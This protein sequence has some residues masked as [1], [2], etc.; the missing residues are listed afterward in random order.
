MSP[1]PARRRT[2]PVTD[3]A[4]LRAAIENASAGDTITLNADVEVASYVEIT[5]SITIDLAGHKISR[6]GN[7][8]LDPMGEGVTLTVKDSVGG[9]EVASVIPVWVEGGADFV[10]ESGAIRSTATTDG[11]GI[12]ADNAGTVTVKGGTVS[13]GNY[14]IN[15]SGATA[16]TIN[17]GT[18]TTAA[19]GA[20]TIA[21]FGTSAIEVNGGTISAT[22][23]DS[24]A[25]SDNGNAGNN[26]NI[27]INDGVVTS[28]HDIAIYKPAAGTLTLNGGTI[29]GGTGVYI[30]SGKLVVPAESTA[31]VNANGEK[32]AFTHYGNGALSTGDAVI[33]ENCNYPGGA[34]QAA[35]AG[36]TF[37]SDNAAPVLSVAY[38][39]P[40]SEAVEEPIK[41]FVSGG[42]YSAALQ[43][44]YLEKGLTLQE[45][46]RRDLLGN[47]D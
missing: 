3:E 5:K 32:K 30:K 33:I 13:G 43:E 8:L 42:T 39:D 7:A 36:G 21:L 37:K 11:Y 14:A 10:L 17:D 19:E 20:F 9:G 23:I 27:T 44:E 35:I 46:Q 41:A 1:S 47:E 25:I 31:V 15:A 29:T 26:C 6:D 28:T 22:G 24:V 2:L 38:D 34:P 18:I 40:A 12:Y 45:E 4:S 16:V